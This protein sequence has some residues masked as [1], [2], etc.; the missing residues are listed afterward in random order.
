MCKH[1]YVLYLRENVRRV[2]TT[3]H[4]FVSPK[5]TFRISNKT[6]KRTQ[7]EHTNSRKR[8]R[9]TIGERLRKEAHV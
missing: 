1:V 9:H 7:H 6:H 5:E 4:K 8:T 2:S 3:V